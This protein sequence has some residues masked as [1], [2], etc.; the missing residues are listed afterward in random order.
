M[1]AGGDALLGGL[2]ADQYIGGAGIDL[3]VFRSTEESNG[4][5]IDTILDFTSGTDKIDLTRIDAD[6]NT[7]GDQAFRFISDAAFSGSGMGGELRSTTDA[8]GQSVLEGDVNGDGV[9]DFTV[10]VVNSTPTMPAPLIG[11]DFIR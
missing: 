11:T 6:T 7:D 1:S 8:K 5:S 4:S 3:F 10:F 2:G 9:S